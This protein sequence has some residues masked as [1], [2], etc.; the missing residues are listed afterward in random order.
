MNLEPVPQQYIV[1]GDPRRA[2]EGVFEGEIEALL[3]KMKLEKLAHLNRL[4]TSLDAVSRNGCHA[5]VARPISS[6]TD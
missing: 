1:S 6:A 4:C 3:E 5:A 2:A